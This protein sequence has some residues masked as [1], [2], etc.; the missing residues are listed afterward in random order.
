MTDTP[1]YSMTWYSTRKLFTAMKEAGADW[2][3]YSSMLRN[4]YRGKLTIPKNAKGERRFTQDMI[5][6]IVK[7]FTPGGK[8]E[9]HYNAHE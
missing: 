9:W 3:T 8:G 7:A 6:E 2:H 5:D 4:E 1:N